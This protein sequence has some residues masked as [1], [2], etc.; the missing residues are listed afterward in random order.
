M[1][2]RQIDRNTCVRLAKRVVHDIGWRAGT[3]FNRLEGT[4]LAEAVLKRARDTAK[5]MAAVTADM[6]V[7]SMTLPETVRNVNRSARSSRSKTMSKLAT[8]RRDALNTVLNFTANPMANVVNTPWRLMRVFMHEARG[9]DAG[10]RVAT[11]AEMRA[12]E[13]A[14]HRQWSDVRIDA[15]EAVATPKVTKRSASVKRSKRQQLQDALI[16]QQSQTKQILECKLQYYS[17]IF[18]CVITKG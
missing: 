9:H 2:I 3:E 8:F 1:Q 16:K 10:V 6:L 18:Y 11:K 15:G 12:K 14:L 5:G 17:F 4:A 13:R 7:L